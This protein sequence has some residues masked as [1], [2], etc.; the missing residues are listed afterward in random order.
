MATFTAEPARAG[1]TVRASVG[2]E[3]SRRETLAIAAAAVL[4][5]VVIVYLHGGFAN[6]AANL[7]DN[8]TYMEIAQA[9]RAHNV[10]TLPEVKAFWGLSYAIAAVSTIARISPLTSLLFISWAASLAAVVLSHKLWGGWAATWCALNQTWIVL[11]GLG[12]AEPLFFALLVGTFLAVRKQ[13]WEVAALLAALATLVRPMGIFALLGIGFELART[14]RWK[15]LAAAT[16]IGAAIGAAYVVP[17]WLNFG[18]PWANLHG[19]MAADMPGGHLLTYPFH[20]LIVSLFAEPRWH[21]V[22]DGARL[23]FWIVASVAL[24]LR[25]QKLGLNSVEAF[26]IALYSLL[27]LCLNVDYVLSGLQRYLIPLLPFLLLAVRP[28]WPQRRVWMY[29]AAPVS[30]FLAAGIVIGYRNVLPALV[31]WK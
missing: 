28:W 10:Q 20:Q 6:T 22:L 23:L 11:S 2:V 12:G 4:L 13:R 29:L 30:T 24:V 15:T 16:A 25:R 31:H 19:Y 17:L 14:R 18:S 7:C 9:I 21:D 26:F 8:G 5:Y 3:P 1:A 27:L